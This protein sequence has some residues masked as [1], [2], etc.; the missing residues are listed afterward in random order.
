M[1]RQHSQETFDVGLQVLLG[2]LLQGDEDGDRVVTNL[3]WLLYEE[4]EVVGV[5]VGAFISSADAE[6]DSLFG[7][8]PTNPLGT[9]RGLYSAPF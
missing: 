5:Q 2:Y 9:K 6:T 3:D 1:I 7:Q 4:V 8:F